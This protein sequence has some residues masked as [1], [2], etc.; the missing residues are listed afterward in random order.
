[1]PKIFANPHDKFIEDYLNTLVPRLLNRDRFVFGKHKN[2]Y[3][4]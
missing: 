4:V 3:L 1:M 2:G